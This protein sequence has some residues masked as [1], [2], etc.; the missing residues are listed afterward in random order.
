MICKHCGT[1]KVHSFFNENYC[2][3]ECYKSAVY[4][5]REEGY[6]LEWKAKSPEEKAF[7]LKREKV[8]R[9]LEEL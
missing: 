4:Q 7:I 6:R 5:A 8:R 1:H 3:K 2:S 9:L